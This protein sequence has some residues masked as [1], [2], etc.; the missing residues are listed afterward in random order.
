MF[1]ILEVTGYTIEEWREVSRGSED[2]LQEHW[3]N[4]GERSS[5]VQLRQLERKKSGFKKVF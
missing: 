3:N 4:P 1:F 2:L 5:C